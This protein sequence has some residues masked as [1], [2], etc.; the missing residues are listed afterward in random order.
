[1]KMLTTLRKQMEVIRNPSLSENLGGFH[2]HHVGMGH[3]SISF[4]GWWKTY[5][6][7]Y[8]VNWWEGPGTIPIRVR[9]KV[10]HR[11]MRTAML[12]KPSVLFEE[13]YERPFDGQCFFLLFKSASRNASLE[14][15]IRRAGYC[16]FEDENRRVP[17]LIQKISFIASPDAGQRWLAKAAFLELL[18]QLHQSLYVEDSGIRRIVPLVS[19]QLLADSGFRQNVFHSLKE[20]PSITLAGLA[21]LLGTSRS[22]LSHRFTR[23]IGE[24][25]AHLKNRLRLERANELLANSSM[26]IKEIAFTSGFDDAAYFTRIFQKATGFSPRQYR[27]MIHRESGRQP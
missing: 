2:L 5:L 7:F 14:T 24:P 17:Q 22:T 1:M 10:V 20:H 18:A 6:D 12:Q 15:L 4:T 21:K 11:P 16:L 3:R 27:E 25:F 8:I 19:N 26:Q 13:F 9:G 23:E